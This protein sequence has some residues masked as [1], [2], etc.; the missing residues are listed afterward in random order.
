LSFDEELFGNK[1]WLFLMM[2]HIH[3]D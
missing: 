1:R 3:I 2:Q